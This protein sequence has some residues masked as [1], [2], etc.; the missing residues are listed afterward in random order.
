MQMRR[1]RRWETEA[2]KCMLKAEGVGE[3][4]KSKV[5]S[6]PSPSSVPSTQ[7]HIRATPNP[8]GRP[9]LGNRR[10]TKLR[11]PTNDNST[12]CAG[13]HNSAARAPP[14]PLA[15]SRPARRRGPPFAHTHARSPGPRAEQGRSRQPPRPA[16]GEARHA[17][18]THP[19]CC[20]AAGTA[21][22][23]ATWRGRRSAAQRRCCPAASVRPRLS[24]P[25]TPSRRPSHT[26]ALPGQRA[27]PSSAHSQLNVADRV[28]L[29]GP[30][31]KGPA[32]PV[33]ATSGVSLRGTNCPSSTLGQ[34]PFLPASCGDARVTISPEP[35]WNL[36]TCIQ[37]EKE[38]RKNR[39]F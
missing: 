25:A 9:A 24:A 33:L 30:G 22:P 39:F 11:P 38:V 17:P 18:P 2:G 16:L 15:G 10:R 27:Q 37:G 23:A 6:S 36:K 32:D 12:R 1:Q 5:E 4:P 28:L 3:D 13:P 21:A 8:N 26:P 31:Y 7:S 34:F 19:W 29:Q 20:S 14:R 35:R